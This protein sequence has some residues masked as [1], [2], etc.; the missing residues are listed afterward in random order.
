MVENAEDRLSA[1]A[2][3]L[4]YQRALEL[5]ERRT[6][7]ALGM[8]GVRKQNRLDVEKVKQENRLKIEKIK[9]NKKDETETAF[10]KDIG[11]LTN[12]FM[13]ADETLDKT[14]AKL[15]AIKVL[16]TS[17]SRGV[18]IVQ[19]SI[20]GSY[21]TENLILDSEGFILEEDKKSGRF[22]RKKQDT[23]LLTDKNETP[24]DEVKKQ[25]HKPAAKDYSHLWK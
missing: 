3:E 15:K 18:K 11:T 13:E 14:A 10:S 20:P 16:K 23:G 12:I 6:N 1:Q 2:E 8:E 17:P 9:S 25:V 5:E 21:R 4:K 24:K 19:R 7:K 22:V